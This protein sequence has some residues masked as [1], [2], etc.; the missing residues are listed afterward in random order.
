MKNILNRKIKIYIPSVFGKEINRMS[1][2]LA[3]KFGGVTVYKTEGAGIN[4]EGELI[5]ENVT[6]IEA[7]YQEKKQLLV[8]AHMID[9]ALHVKEK[10]KRDCVAMEYEE[11]M[12]I[13]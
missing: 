2:I 9:L 10:C 8:L 4:D 3:K 12:Y 1:V 5:K 11:E 6:V 7:W 13:V